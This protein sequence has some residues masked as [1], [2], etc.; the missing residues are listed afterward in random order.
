MAISQVVATAA[1]VAAYVAILAIARRRRRIII[2][3]L[4]SSRFCAV[5]TGVDVAALSDVTYDNIRN[6]FHSHGG[7]LLIRGQE[8]CC[9]MPAAVKAFA[10]RFGTLET[11]EKYHRMKMEHQLHSEEHQEILCVGNALGKRSMLIAVDPSR[12][13]LWHCDDS[14][15]APQP[16]GSCFFCIQAPSSGAATHFASGTAAWRALP[17]TRQRELRK[18]AAF[19]DYN[20]LNERLREENPTRAPL[21]AEV[22]KATP[23]ILRPLVA[24]H[25]ETSEEALYVPGCHIARV[26]DLTN[27]AEVPFDAIIPPLVDH[28]T[29]PERSYAH[30]WRRGDLIIWDN[31]NTLHA[32]SHFDVQ[33]ETR[34]MWRITMFGPDITPS[35]ETLN[36]ELAETAAA[37]R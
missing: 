6:A 23:P 35:P 20:A 33:C 2:R 13:L 25:P 30:Q 37:L 12:P 21:S 36:A 29:Q 9:E 7:L 8:R 11:N 1:A 19:H 18:L 27:G 4:T 34:L 31:R 17:E 5:V 28:V 3:P 14:F 22:K 15:R 16:M 26:V 10:A 32:P 24:R